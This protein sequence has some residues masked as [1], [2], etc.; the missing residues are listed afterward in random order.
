QRLESEVAG[1]RRA[2]ASRGVIEQAK[3]VLAE[4]LGC[5]PDEAFAHLSTMSQRS[6]VRLA[7]VA[8]SLLASMTGGTGG[9]AAAE[10]RGDP[11]TSTFA[12][13]L[14][15]APIY[16]DLAAH[17]A[18]CK[19]LSEF[20]DVMLG[21]G[22]E[23]EVAAVYDVG[24]LAE[25]RGFAIA[26]HDTAAGDDAAA[27]TV[28]AVATVRPDRETN[29]AMVSAAAEAVTTDRPV[30]RHGGQPLVRIAAFPLPGVDSVLG[31]VVLGWRAG[32]TAPGPW[33]AEERRYLG[34]LVPVAQRAAA[35]LWGAP[36]HPVASVL[37]T[38]YDPGLLLEPVRDDGQIVDFV[39]EYASV[40]VPDMAGLSR[41]EQIGRRLLDT[42]PHLGKSGV[43]HAYMR[44]LET[45]EPW[46]R[47]AQQETVVVDGAPTIITVA[48]RAIRYGRGL[49]VTWHRDDDRV[50]RTAVAADGGA[51]PLRLGGLGSR[52][53]ADVLVARNVPDLRSRPGARSD[54]V[55]HPRR[56]GRRLGAGRRH[57]DG[58][59]RE[60]R[61]GRR[62]RVPVGARLE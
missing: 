40:D 41:A 20:A 22:L 17:A 15:F 51:R 33:R 2:M 11:D 37:D 43:F 14:E 8:A 21:A 31:A 1:L 13:P 27:R 23:P 45:G 53:S 60:S 57:G 54:A 5:S 49:L 34:A 29:D 59:R 47:G 39:I 50:R 10:N 55:R 28:G 6:N 25:P 61:S 48:R 35:R 12:L 46:V 19:D 44:V 7:D 16:R 3:G 58:E 56:R 26:E 30:W 62:R 18:V 9:D 52:R 32:R 42:Y 24:D 36:S 38:G 4:R